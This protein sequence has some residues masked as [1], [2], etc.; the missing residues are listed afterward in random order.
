MERNSFILKQALCGI[1]ALLYSWISLA[2]V[3]LVTT[4]NDSG[5]GSLREAITNLAGPGDTIRFASSLS[6]DTVRLTSGEIIFPV[7]LSVSVEGLGEHFTFISGTLNSRIFTIHAGD[8]VTIKNITL[9]EGMAADSG[10]AIK[11]DGH[12]TISYCT[13]SGNRAHAGGG[14]YN[15]ASLTMYHCTL[16]NNQA[17][18]GQGGGIYSASGMLTA[19]NCSITNNNATGNGGGASCLAPCT[20]DS[21]SVIANEANQS[22]GGLY[23]QNAPLVMNNSTL[24][25]NTA[26]GGNGGAIWNSGNSKISDCM[27]TDNQVAGSSASGGGVYN[28]STLLL[29]RVSVMRNTSQTSGAGISNSGNLTMNFS[30][31]AYNEAVGNG[32]GFFNSGKALL[33]H[34]TISNNSGLNGGGVYNTGKSTLTFCTLAEN[35]AL[36]TGGGIATGDSLL[37]SNTLIGYNVTSGSG[38]NL[39]KNGGVIISSGHNLVQNIFPLTSADFSPATG[40]KLGT[41][42]NPIDPLL[43]PLQNNGGTTETHLPRCGSPAIDAADATVAPAFDQRGFPRV[44]GTAPDIGA[45]EN[46]EDPITV[47]AIITAIS[48]PGKS[49]GSIQLQVSGGTPPYFYHWNDG[50]S[51]SIKT[52]LGA[53]N[54]GVTVEDFNG[55]SAAGVFTISDVINSVWTPDKGTIQVYNILADK[56]LI[57]ESK[58]DIIKSIRIY[59]LSGRLLI[60]TPESLSPSGRIAVA[61]HKLSAGSYIVSAEMLHADHT[62]FISERFALL[63]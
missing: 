60:Q 33:N 27:I 19:L 47:N 7:N 1:S 38:N 2:N 16:S 39:F 31:V 52:G 45:T 14:I 15:K 3:I 29:V 34:C 50:D 41:N 49:D 36:T 61:I 43:G 4:T 37:F 42:A 25:D 48:E 5:P 46:Q 57:V 13:I 59:D 32:G 8:T 24:Q 12:L 9:T 51:I 17:S 40:D 28:V 26:Q 22:G 35:T 55:C 11:N 18:S 62:W 20:F 44:H 21:T 30:T 58:Q 53:G 54:Y 6:G 63:R 23:I 56:Q 10:G